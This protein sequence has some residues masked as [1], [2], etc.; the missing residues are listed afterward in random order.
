MQYAD[1]AAQAYAHQKKSAVEQGVTQRLLR[2]SERLLRC[3]ERLLRCSECLLRCSERLLWC[4]ERLLRCFER[5]LWCFEH[6]DHTLTFENFFS[7]PADFFNSVFALKDCKT[8][9]NIS[10]LFILH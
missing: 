7:A 1:A 10:F 5:L 3:S 4:F 2:C 6:F 9:S 8:F